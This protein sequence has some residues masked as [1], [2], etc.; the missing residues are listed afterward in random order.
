MF[1][2]ICIV[3]PLYSH[4]TKST[5]I[6]QKHSTH[7]FGQNLTIPY[8]NS[9]SKSPKNHNKINY[10]HITPTQLPHPNQTLINSTQINKISPK[11]PHSYNTP[12]KIFPNQKKQN[13]PQQNSTQT[14]N[15]TTY[16][17][18]QHLNLT[19]HQT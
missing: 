7:L 5:P 12:A 11:T 6:S 14:P 19:I 8:P 17:Q 16:N 3:V 15:N 18:N 10:L 2:R 1:R 9:L 4:T 13:K